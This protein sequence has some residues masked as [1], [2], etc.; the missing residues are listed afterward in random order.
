MTTTVKERPILF[1]DPM[2]RAIRNNLKTETRRIVKHHLPTG[3]CDIRIRKAGGGFQIYGAG[4]V[5]LPLKCPYGDVGTRLWVREAWQPTGVSV[6]KVQVHY[7]AD[8]DA[9]WLEWDRPISLVKQTWRPS[10]HM[11]RRLS[12]I[13]LEI[14]SVA[15]E[16]LHDI[17]E[18][19]AIREGF[20]RWQHREQGEIS[21]SQQFRDLWHKINGEPSW[22]ANPWVWVVAFR[23][24][25]NG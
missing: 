11:P 8:G 6:G 21:A 18:A 15:V 16:R 17:T 3:P 10:I 24:I 23:R 25:P 4:G 1:S 22:A 2:V 20:R 5:W 13:T 12:R 19:A 7:R 9:K 14:V